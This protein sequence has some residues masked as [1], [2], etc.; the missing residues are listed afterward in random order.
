M[1]A[2]FSISY[3]IY[4]NLSEYTNSSQIY[5]DFTNLSWYPFPRMCYRQEVELRNHSPAGYV[6][7]PSLTKGGACEP[8]ALASGKLT[9]ATARLAWSSSALRGI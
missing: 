5:L 8:T 9:R 4:Y 1:H 2:D 6:K 3:Q 7:R